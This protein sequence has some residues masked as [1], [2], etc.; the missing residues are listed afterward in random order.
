MGVE[1]AIRAFGEAERP[2][3]IEGEAFHRRC[4]QANG[5][6]RKAL[7]VVTPMSQRS[8]SFLLLFFKKEALAFF[9]SGGLDGV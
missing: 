6:A 3:D 7:P 9:C 2:V 8:E 4:I 1:V 5:G